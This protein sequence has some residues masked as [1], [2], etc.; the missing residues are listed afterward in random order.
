MVSAGTLGIFW[1]ASWNLLERLVLSV[2]VPVSHVSE[3]GAEGRYARGRVGESRYGSRQ[4]GAMRWIEAWAKTTCVA[5]SSACSGL[6]V[7]VQ[8]VSKR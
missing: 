7:G 1:G 3:G 6:P 4:F 5:S 8:L 2:V